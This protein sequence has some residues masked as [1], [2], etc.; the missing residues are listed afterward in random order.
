MTKAAPLVSQLR[1]NLT[2]GLSSKSARRILHSLQ[3]KL[4]VPSG[5]YLDGDLVHLGNGSNFSPEIAGFVT[6]ADGSDLSERD[7][8]KVEAWLAANPQVTEFSMGPLE[9]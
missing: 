8:K 9:P 5:L 4:L 1:A 3:D 7:R 6:R 2:H